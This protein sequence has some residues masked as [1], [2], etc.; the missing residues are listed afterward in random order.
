MGIE[1]SKCSKMDISAILPVS[2]GDTSSSLNDDFSA[3]TPSGDNVFQQPMAAKTLYKT[4][5]GGVVLIGFLFDPKQKWQDNA[6]MASITTDYMGEIRDGMTKMLLDAK[7]IAPKKKTLDET[8]WETFTSTIPKETLAKNVFSEKDTLSMYMDMVKKTV[9]V[10]YNEEEKLT[11]ALKTQKYSFSYE[12]AIDAYPQELGSGGAKD[13][14]P[15]QKMGVLTFHVE[16]RP[17]GV[18]PEPVFDEEDGEKKSKKRKLDND[19]SKAKD[20]KKAKDKAL[21]ELGLKDL[22]SGASVTSEKKFPLTATQFFEGF[23][24]WFSSVVSRKAAKLEK[25][26]NRNPLYH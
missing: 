23:N 5:N 3:T 19:S 8:L 16:G 10:T 4:P 14:K 17:D 1:V 6:I 12:I 20:H 24:R 26:R 25:Q 22:F 15:P 21:N 2:M 7:D 9:T 13:Q 18:L 11:E